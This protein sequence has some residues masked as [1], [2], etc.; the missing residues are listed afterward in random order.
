MKKTYNSQSIS[1][2]SLTT[3]TNNSQ[4]ISEVIQ[5]LKQK[6]A[7]NENE[8]QLLFRLIEEEK[9]EDDP[10][11]LQILRDCLQTLEFS[12][13]QG[14]ACLN[15]L[16]Q[17]GETLD[18]IDHKLEHIET[19]IQRSNRLLQSIRSG[20]HSFKNAFFKKKIHVKDQTRPRS[21]DQRSLDQRSLDQTMEDQRSKSKSMLISDCARSLDQKIEDQLLDQMSRSISHFNQIGLTMNQELIKQN[22][23]IKNLQNKTDDADFG[24]SDLNNQIKN[25]L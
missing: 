15:E 24:I 7:I 17:Q 1:K 8:E 6:E 3:Q 5:N 25:L 18:R 13:E 20:W 2:F 22:E 11:M 4:S 21:I 10:V 19:N 14:Q 12:K 16:L 9:E 23:Q